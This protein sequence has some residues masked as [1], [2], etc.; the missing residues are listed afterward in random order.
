MTEG[1][2]RSIN[3]SISRP[4]EI[5]N[6][7]IDAAI[8]GSTDTAVLRMAGPASINT[9]GAFTEVT[10]A[11][12][13]TVVIVGLPGLYH[14]SFYWGQGGPRPLSLGIGVDMVTGAPI[15]SDAV[16]TTAGMIAVMAPDGV[17]GVSM[18]GEL[19]ATFS[20]TQAQAAIG[21]TVRMIGTNPVDGIPLGLGNQPQNNAYRIT[22]I[23]E[24]P[25]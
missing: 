1:F 12:N 13:G 5:R 21:R 17:G 4:A 9:G 20:V 25:N 18:V 22:K 3:R 14:V 2:E 16:W 24:I 7:L 15:V 8:T 11:A 10:T 6:F 19:S 23:A